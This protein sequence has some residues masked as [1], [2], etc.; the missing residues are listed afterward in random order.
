MTASTDNLVNQLQELLKQ[1]TLQHSLAPDTLRAVTTELSELRDKTKA[2][3]RR[4][5]HLERD[6]QNK[7]R[8]IDSYKAKV[9]ELESSLETW[10]CL[11]D[12]IKARE[13]AMT[14]LEITS[15]M[16]QQRGDEF[17]GLLEKFLRNTSYRESLQTTKPM[18]LDGGP[19][20][21]GWVQEHQEKTDKSITAE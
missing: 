3:G 20:G 21:C 5:E 16:Q 19:Q 18:A 6:Q 7:L 12:N 1:E 10:E 2:Q 13:D 11:E 17:H 8:E 4:I 9:R 14:R 15:E